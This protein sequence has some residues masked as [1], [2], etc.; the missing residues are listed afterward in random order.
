MRITNRSR[1][2]L[3]SNVRAGKLALLVGKYVTVDTPIPS[4][5][6]PGTVDVVTCRYALP[7]LQY[8]RC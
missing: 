7:Y 4:V 2:R 6:R 5:L 8:E 3:R 1:H